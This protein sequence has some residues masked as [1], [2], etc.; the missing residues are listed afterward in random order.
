MKTPISINE[1]GDI[2]I[3]ASAEEAESYMEPIDV[4]RGEYVVTDADGL[5]LTVDIVVKE[6]PLLWG[7]W[8]GR[9]RKVR[10][11]DK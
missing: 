2:S 11:I 4:E 1:R 7:L 6:V 5:H 8:K 10:I 3:F 9:V